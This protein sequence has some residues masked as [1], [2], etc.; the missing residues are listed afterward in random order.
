MVVT[1]DPALEKRLR[2]LRDHGVD[3]DAYQRHASGRIGLAHYRE[4]A[5]N[6]RMTDIQGAIGTV[7]L[8]RLAEMIRKRRRLAAH[9]RSRLSGRWGVRTAGDPPYGR[10]NFQSFWITLPDDL[11]VDRDGILDGLLDRGIS[12]RPGFM[13]AHLEPAYAGDGAT[14]RVRLPTTERLTQRTLILPLHHGLNDVD[15]DEIVDV[16]A[17]LVRPGRV[18]HRRGALVT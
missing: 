3:V 12:A 5:F 17:E 11:S 14:P 10:T 7:Q 8:D 18:A 13:A 2:A 16:L 4:P 6:Y 9:Y 1:S 15:V